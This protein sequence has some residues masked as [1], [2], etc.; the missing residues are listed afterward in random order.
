V[1][2]SDLLLLAQAHEWA[3]AGKA[4]QLRLD[5]GLLQRQIAAHCGVTQTAVSHW[6]LAER[7]RP[8]GRA[9]LRWARLLDDLA[10]REE[11][12]AS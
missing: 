10:A 7:K 3:R 1:R 6:E 4:R 9:A 2:R 8:A 11:R 5:A 12:A